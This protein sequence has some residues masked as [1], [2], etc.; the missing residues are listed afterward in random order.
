MRRRR[1]DEVA[2]APALHLV[3]GDER[4]QQL[5]A[6]FSLALGGGE[7]RRH[8]ED[9]G[10]REHVVR[11]ALVVHRDRHAV[12]ECRARA[13]D[14]RAVD[15]QRRALTRP[16]PPRAEALVLEHGA[17]RGGRALV[18][19]AHEAD[20]HGVVHERL[21]LVDDGGRQLLVAEPGG[22]FSEPHRE[23]CLFHTL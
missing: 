10:M 1:R 19:R 15:P 3:A 23:R 2:R 11:V 7:A 20:R 14:P 16:E 4:R 22:E 6:G 17:P 21:R 13:R 5:A 8:D 12:C 18:A 9:A